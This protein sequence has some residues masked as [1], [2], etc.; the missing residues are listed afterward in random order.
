MAKGEGPGK[1]A[2]E[3]LLVGAAFKLLYCYFI[4][5]FLPL[6]FELFF[7]LSFAVFRRGR[8]LMCC[9]LKKVLSFLLAT[10]LLV[11]F[12]STSNRIFIIIIFPS[13]IRTMP[14]HEGV[15]IAWNERRF[16][17]EC[18]RGTVMTIINSKCPLSLKY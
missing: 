6:K 9:L 13:T 11:I 5:Y 18:M 14:V 15:A 3:T 1:K 8:V 4:F 10:I 12:Q 2:G 7:V 16:I 17:R